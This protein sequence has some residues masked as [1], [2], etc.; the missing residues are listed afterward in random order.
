MRRLIIASILAFMSAV[1]VSPG[2]VFPQKSSEKVAYEKP[3]RY[4]VKS[5]E[6][7]DLMDNKRSNRKVPL[8][9]HFPAAGRNFPLVIISHGGGGNWDANIYQAQHLA[10]HGYVVICTEHVYSNNIQ[11]R[12]YM[13]RA[14]GRMGFMESLHRI[15]TDPQAV[16]QRPKDVSFAIDQAMVWMIENK[17]LEGKINARKIAAIGHSFG[18]YTTLVVCGA[19]P[20][21]DFL[22]PDKPPGRGLAGDLSD[23]RVTFGFA[24]SPQSPGGTFFGGDSYKTINRPLVCLTG[25]KDVQKSSDGGLMPPYTRLEV[26]K[27]LPSGEK[28]FFWLENADHLSFSDNPRA[29]LLP[30]QARPDAQRVSKALMVLF[31]D[32]FLKDDKKALKNLNQDYLDSLCGDVVT[33]IKLHKK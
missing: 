11:I 32:Y 25:S 12:Y 28:Y 2:E 23:S 14:G 5:L 15:T 30:S 4:R 13:S 8:K 1:L 16:L 21:L 27:L 9:I 7:P 29:Y 24:M 6:F 18:A 33:E 10:S 20:I 26:L 19:Q 17:E 3:G 22:E 31:C